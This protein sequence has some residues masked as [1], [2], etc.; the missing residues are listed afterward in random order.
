M[1]KGFRALFLLVILATPFP[2]FSFTEI[3]G[4]SFVKIDKGKVSIR[5]NGKRCVKDG[6]TIKA[7]GVEVK[8]GEKVVIKACRGIFNMDSGNFLFYKGVIRKRGVLMNGSEIIFSGRDLIVR[9]PDARIYH[10]DRAYKIVAVRAKIS[11]NGERNLIFEGKASLISKDLRMEGGRICLVFKGEKLE[12]I[13][14]KGGVKLFVGDKRASSEK[15]FWNPSERRLRLEG[16]A[17]IKEGDSVFRS[18]KVDYFIKKGIFK[19]EG[20]R[21][22]FFFG[23]SK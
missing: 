13:R 2:L 18:D 20:K 3:K 4:F 1:G 10:A 23:G 8:Y 15:L 9:D 5:V 11:G 12:E 14:A 21:I 16:K 17:V 22:R 7:E 6:N 19:S